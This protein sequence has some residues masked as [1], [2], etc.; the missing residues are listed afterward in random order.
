MQRRET[1]EEQSIGLR[2]AA[3]EGDMH[4]HH[5]QPNGKVP[6]I[7]FRN[8]GSIGCMVPI[9]QLARSVTGR[10][11]FARGADLRASLGIQKEIC[12]S[13]VMGT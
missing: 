11:V 9:E 6:G 13:Q 5:G 1:S 8:H 4:G 12:R 7:Q 10:M 3:S 2:M